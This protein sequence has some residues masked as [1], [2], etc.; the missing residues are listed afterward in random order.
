MSST[1][2][3]II[4][5]ILLLLIQYVLCTEVLLGGYITPYIYFLYILWL[6][7]TI[8]RTT[9]LFVAAAYG[10]AFGYITQ[11]PGLHAAACVLIAYLRPFII[12]I[13]LPR[14]VK[15]LNYA[16][17][18][19]QSMGLAP[20]SVYVVTLTIV[21]HLYLILLQ[22]ISVSHLTHFIVKAIL[23]TVVSLVLVAI[24]E[25]IVNRT[26]KTRASLQ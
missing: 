11:A 5:A 4:R 22:W 7:F 2:K 1:L 20:Y 21:H 6:P 25:V 19:V 3:Y 16:E 12:S 14:E 17:P 10:L 24:T 13:L 18:S 26:K 15:E 23:S 9:L 8:K